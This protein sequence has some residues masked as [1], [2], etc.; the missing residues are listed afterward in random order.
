MP[1]EMGGE[2][3]EVSDWLASVKGSNARNVAVA[4]AG[5]PQIVK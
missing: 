2:N 4:A 5:T 1:L 3:S